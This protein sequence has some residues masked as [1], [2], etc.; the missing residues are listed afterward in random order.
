MNAFKSASIILPV[1]NETYSLR[2]TVDIIESACANDVGEYIIVVCERT[3]AESLLVCRE[4]VTQLAG[5]CS[6]HFQKRPFVGGA[7]R[8]GFDL[9][10]GSH[11]VMMSTDL[12]TDPALVKTLIAM[13]K[14]YPE[15]I[16]TASRWV[17]GGQFEGYHPIKLAANFLFQK[18]FS[19][20]YGT[21]LSDLTYAYRIFPTALVHRIAWEELKHPFFLETA[22]KPLRLGVTI[23]EIPAVWRAR[24]EGESVN[25]F[26]ANFTYFKIA[27][28]TRFRRTQDI[29]CQ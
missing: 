10:R 29:V 25:P 2:Q 11:V 19:V 21:R 26:M 17:K 9:A 12:E 8:D 1:L 22:L 13:A 7:I 16:A 3:K 4:I 23:R 14:E 18:M 24:T 27:I 15:G 20:L 6:L 5:K 28:R